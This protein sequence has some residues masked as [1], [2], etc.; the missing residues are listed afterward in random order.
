MINCS[1]AGVR[2]DRVVVVAAASDAVALTGRR[3]EV[4]L[5]HH[6][7]MPVIAGY[8]QCPA[9]QAGR[10]AVAEP[11]PVADPSVAAAVAESV[12]APAVAEPESWP[13]FQA[14]N[15]CRHT[16][17]GTGPSRRHRTA[18]AAADRAAEAR[19]GHRTSWCASSESLQRPVVMDAYPIRVVRMRGRGRT[20]VYAGCA[21]ES[22]ADAACRRMRY[23]IPGTDLPSR[24]AH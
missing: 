24:R 15:R 20:A 16:R 22:S 17:S 23:R 4:G 6:E 13:A 12:S 3:I 19:A 18:H 2:H 1:C 9:A 11:P 21:S 8:R 7:R 10:P 5:R 14:P